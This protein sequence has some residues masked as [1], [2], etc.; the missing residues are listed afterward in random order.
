MA[1]PPQ[2]M[3]GA[4]PGMPGPAGPGAAPPAGGG[5]GLPKSPIGGPSGPGS[6]PMVSPGT[7]AGM[8]AAALRGTTKVIET[9]MGYARAFE[10]GTQEFGVYMRAINA[11][12]ALHKKTGGQAASAPI[13]VA[14]TPPG[15]GLGGGGTP[16]AGGPSNGPAGSPLGPN[17]AMA[18]LMED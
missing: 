7:G 8:Q 13:P 1:L 3:P 12:N 17:T 18:P 14:P 11:L 15:A 5:I 16:P 4:G 6:S 10:P 2:P 9:L